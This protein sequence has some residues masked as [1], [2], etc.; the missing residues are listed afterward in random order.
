MR[1]APQLEQAAHTVRIL[2]VE[3][4]ADFAALV[5]LYVAGLAGRPVLSAAQTLEQA[6]EALRAAAFDLVLTDLGLPDC[7][8]LETLERIAAV[9]A[10][11]IIVLTGGRG[12]GDP[13]RRARR[14]RLRVH[15]EVGPQRGDARAPGAPR[16]HAGE[17]LPVAAPERGALPQPDAALLRLVL[18][19]GQRVPAHLHVEPHGRA[20]RARPVRLHRTQALGPAGAQPDGRRLGAPPRAARAPRAVPRVRDAAQDEDGGSVWLSISGEPVYDADGRFVGYRGVGRDITAQKRAQA[21]LERFR[22]ALDRSADMFFLVDMK[23]NRVL[24]FNET[25]C[26]AL[27]YAREELTGVRSDLILAGRTLEEIRA[28][29]EELLRKRMQTGETMYRRKDG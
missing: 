11:P 2:L 1:P 24:D 18:G 3:D 16:R 9:T 6:L 27:G 21:A 13:R 5:H 26:A 15:A 14:R 8:G 29:H 25:A 7:S 20:H 23:E 22:T 19:A 17:D 10:C 28:S 4:D 12:P